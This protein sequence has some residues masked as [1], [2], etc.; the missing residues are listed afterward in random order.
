MLDAQVNAKKLAKE[1]DAKAN[2]SYMKKWV[3]QS[4]QENAK[5]QQDKNRQH[6]KVMATKNFLL[7]QMNSNSKSNSSA[8]EHQFKK[9]NEIG[10][11]MSAE[12]ARMNRELLKEIAKSK[13]DH[14]SI[15]LDSGRV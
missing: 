15:R 3:L 11:Q 8:A 4:E 5:R 13:K 7:G 14:Q 12:E 6:D 2:E 1:N 9:K 10:G